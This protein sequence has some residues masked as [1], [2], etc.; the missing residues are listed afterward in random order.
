MLRIAGLLTISFLLLFTTCIQRSHAV[1]ALPQVI[2]NTDSRIH[3]L[4]RFNDEFQCAWTGSGF[5]IKVTAGDVNVLLHDSAKGVKDK[6]I[7]YNSNYFAVQVD[8]QEPRVLRCE[9]GVERY[10]LFKNE[11]KGEH[12]ITLFR[13]TEA[14][15]GLVTFKGIEISADAELLQAPI[16]EKKLLVLGDSITCGYGNEAPSKD[17]G[18]TAHEENGYMTYAAITARNLNAEYHCVAWSGQGLYR[19]RE[20]RTDSQMPEKLFMKIPHANKK[21]WQFES[22]KPD[23]LIVNLGTNDTAKDIPPLDLFTAAAKNLVVQVRSVAPDCQVY[24]CS[25]P[26]IGGDKKVAMEK[27]YAAVASEFE[28]VYVVSLPKSKWPDGY[29]GHYHPKVSSHEQ[30]AKVLTAAIQ[31]NQHND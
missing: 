22:Y 9:K 6:R 21:D 5:V 27:C 29:G 17:F 15:F 1:E 18:F 28:Q 25:G 11:D 3:L 2:A 14:L 13:R 24:F 8:D 10:L 31:K 7:G 26:M 20:G 23:Y 16:Q 30:C 12:V 4:G 19:N